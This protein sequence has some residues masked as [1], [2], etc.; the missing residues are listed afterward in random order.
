MSSLSAA[1]GTQAAQL[2]SI[3]DTL[4][5]VFSSA[6]G[7]GVVQ[8]PDSL[9]LCRPGLRYGEAPAQPV[10]P[11][12]R[13]FLDRVLQRQLRALGNRRYTPKHAR[14]WLERLEKQG[15][16]L[17]KL[18]HAQRV[19]LLGSLSRS[20]QRN[21]NYPGCTAIGLAYATQVAHE[22]LGLAARSNQLL[23]ARALLQSNCVEMATGEGKTLS[24]ALAASVA[25]L[26]RAPVHILTSNDYLAE[27]DASSMQPFY[28]KLG[29][30]CASALSSMSVDQR[31]A[32]YRADI[33]Y[34]TGKQVAF[35]WLSDSL[36]AGST[37]DTLA[38][39]LESM[40]QPGAGA[41]TAP[42]L[43]GLC[44][45]IV[46]EA[47]SLLIDEARVPL[48][49][50]SAQKDQNVVD[51]ESII[52]LTLAEKLNEG[53][54]FQRVRASG[55]IRLTDEG[56][57]ELEKLSQ[58]ISRVWH[59]ARFREEKVSQAL[60]ALYNFRLNEDYIVR[61]GKLELV[62]VHTGRPL[63]DRRLQ[64]GLH[65]ML[66]LKEKCK[67]TPDHD[68]VASIPFQHFFTRYRSL[69]GISG[70]LHEVRGELMHIY[71]LNVLRIQP[72]RPCQRREMPDKILTNTASQLESMVADVS[73]RHERG[74]P[75]LICT[76]SVEQSM[77]TSAMLQAHGIN[78]TVLNAYQDADEAEIVANAGQ[79]GVVT[80]AT[81]MA[82]RG[83][84]IP[85]G[86]GV[87]SLGGLHV[88]S[89]AFNEARRLDRQIAGRAARQGD[90]GSFQRMISLEDP[91][92][93]EETSD[94]VRKLATSLAG[95]KRHWAA[96]VLVQ[97]VIRRIEWKHKRIRITAYKAREGL[98]RA[99]AF[100]GQKGLL[101]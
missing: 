55:Q 36:A 31:R 47:D 50:A 100:S 21:V 67:P 89:L 65:R 20:L 93:K 81:N 63:P 32:A 60:V 10:K 72:H 14:Q 2:S 4:R 5:R 73:R 27:R 7:P 99:L 52:A 96:S 88:L 97:L 3:R 70:T 17:A 94:G 80:V 41:A 24:I 25:A 54:D 33:T 46:D 75:V 15:E 71:R 86:E 40:T 101:S 9:N 23:A 38:T 45:A 66:E 64:F 58:R 90:P 62:D 98:E 59:S 34:V 92:L 44:L 61:D 76:R 49:L 48:V 39:R 28:E 85:L 6:S 84:D 68:T 18:D 74:Q 91:Y 95:W 82:G 11:D 22:T 42:I 19:A 1:T 79:R 8:S 37:S 57:E 51:T 29:L 69:V 35:D 77:G 12:R 87:A 56:R 26:S 16:R 30:S 43:R 83:T 53:I 78:N 13:N